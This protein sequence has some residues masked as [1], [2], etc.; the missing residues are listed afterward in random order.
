MQ[1]QYQFPRLTRAAVTMLL[2]DEALRDVGRQ[3]PSVYDEAPAHAAFAQTVK[4]RMNVISHDLHR[5]GLHELRK[6]YRHPAFRTQPALREWIAQAYDACKKSGETRAVIYTVLLLRDQVRHYYE[7]CGV[8]GTDDRMPLPSARE[9]ERMRRRAGRKNESG[10]YEDYLV[11]G[12]AVKLVDGSRTPFLDAFD[13]QGWDKPTSFPTKSTRMAFCGVCADDGLSPWWRVRRRTT[14]DGYE[15][16]PFELRERCPTCL[17]VES[18]PRPAT[19]TRIFIH[20]RIV[21]RH[22]Q[23]VMQFT[24]FYRANGH[25]VWAA[26]HTRCHSELHHLLERKWCWTS[27]LRIPK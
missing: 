18:A 19:S 22:G 10:E 11:T 13:T 25:W 2:Q 26:D 16:A 21:K 6:Y 20:R 7:F 15:Q 5:A 1:M 12:D 9:P 23:K 14:K 24:T 3:R 27:R 4:R 17:Y 8:K